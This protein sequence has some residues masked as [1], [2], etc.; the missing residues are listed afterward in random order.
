MAPNKKQHFVPQFYLKQFS[1]D[2]SQKTIGI[3]NFGNYKYNNQ[4]ISLKDQAQKDY[5][6]GRDLIIENA[7]HEQENIASEIFRRITE[8][9][10]IPLLNSPEHYQLLEFLIFLRERTL[11]VV[12]QSKKSA[13]KFIE[14]IASKNTDVLEDISE[15][16]FSSLRLTLDALNMAAISLP[17]AFDLSYKIFVN[18]ANIPFITSD[19]PVVFYNQ[20]LEERKKGYGH[21]GIACKGLQIFL[22]ISPR[23]LIIFFDQGIYKVGSKKNKSI[24]LRQDSDIEA[25]N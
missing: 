16:D 6:Y 3:F 21:I 4:N 12:N 19:H 18:E 14:I 7:F 13:D 15:E 1:L 25:L 10:F 5:F 22:P 8:D 20:F 23:H 2:E 9:G 11:C 24:V 17:L